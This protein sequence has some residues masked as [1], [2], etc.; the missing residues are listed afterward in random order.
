MIW[1]APPGWGS[2][3]GNIFKG[4]CTAH[5]SNRHRVTALSVGKRLR[6]QMRPFTKPC[7]HNSIEEPLWEQTPIQ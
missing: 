4:S 6:D 5:C 3:L 2:A 1:G 7:G